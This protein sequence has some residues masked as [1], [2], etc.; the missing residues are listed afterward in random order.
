ML[1]LIRGL[2]HKPDV[3]FY[4]I[5]SDCPQITYSKFI[6]AQHSEM[7]PS[8]DPRFPSVP[9]LLPALLVCWAVCL[10]VFVLPRHYLISLRG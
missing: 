5:V 6:L 4:K 9:Q 10:L 2:R 7:P 3:V 8:S 1:I